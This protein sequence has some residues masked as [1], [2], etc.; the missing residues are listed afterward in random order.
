LPKLHATCKTD[1][2][3]LTLA[4]GVKGGNLVNCFVNYVSQNDKK[5]SVRDAVGEYLKPERTGL[6]RQKRTGNPLQNFRDN[7]SRLIQ[8]FGKK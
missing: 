8:I 4:V 2:E 6:S 7:V 1:F 5:N 3:K